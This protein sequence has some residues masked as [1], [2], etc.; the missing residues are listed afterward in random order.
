MAERIAKFKPLQLYY[1]S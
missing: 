1:A